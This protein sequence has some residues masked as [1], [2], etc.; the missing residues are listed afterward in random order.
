MFHVS[1]HDHYTPSQAIGET[2]ALA[3]AVLLPLA[4][5]WRSPSRRGC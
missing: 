1:H 3:I 2:S 4:L 5:S